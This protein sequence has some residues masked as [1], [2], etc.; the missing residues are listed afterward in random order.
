MCDARKGEGMPTHMLTRPGE[1]GIRRLRRVHDGCRRLDK[2]L[3][4]I[5]GRS[6]PPF[7]RI[8]TYVS[9]GFKPMRG[10]DI[11]RGVAERIYKQFPDVVVVVV[12]SDRVCYGGD[13]EHTWHKTFIRT[14][15][16]RIRLRPG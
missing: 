8:L 14:R 7:T 13:E 5:A 2:V 4:M 12:G 3:R 15:D 16:G 6:I 10:F 11:L 1:G 9:R